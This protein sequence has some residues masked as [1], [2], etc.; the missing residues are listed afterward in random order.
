M[1][2][3]TD[4]QRATLASKSNLNLHHVPKASIGINFGFDPHHPSDNLFYSPPSVLIR[5]VFEPIS[6]IPFNWK[7]RAVIQQTYITNFIPALPDIILNDDFPQ[8]DKAIDQTNPRQFITNGH[9]NPDTRILPTSK[10]PAADFPVSV[11]LP[12]PGP[13]LENPVSQSHL[14]PISDHFV[15]NTTSTPFQHRYPIHQHRQPAHLACPVL[16]SPDTTAS[17]LSVSDSEK[18]EFTIKKGLL[19]EDYKHAVQP[20]ITKEL[21]KMFLTYKALHFINKTDVPANAQFFRFFLFLKLK[22]LPD[23]SFERMSARLCA[24][25]TT[26]LP[27]NA[28]TAYAATGDHHLF[29]LTVNAVLAAAKLEGYL[30]AVQLRRYDIPGAFLQRPLPFPYYGRLPSDLPPPYCN[31]YVRVERCIYGARVSNKI[32]DDDHTATILSIGYSQFEGDPRKFRIVCPTD[33]TKFVIINT[34]VDDGGVIHTWQAKYDET[35]RVLGNRYPGTLDETEMDRYLGMGF[36]Y[37]PI[38]GALTASMYHSIVKA[39]ATFRT[40]SLPIQ[41]TP[42]TMDLFDLTTDPAPVDPVSYQRIVGICIWLLQIRFDIQLPTIMAC[43]HNKAPTQG[44]LIKIIRVLS[45]LK[46][47]AD[48]GPTFLTSDGPTLIASCDAA[49]GV[50]PTTGGSQLSI[51]FRIGKD[52]APFHVISHVQRTKISLNPTHSEYNAFSI[53]TEHIKF[54]RTYLSWLGF[55]Q[56]APT[57]LETDCAP[58]ISILEAPHFP[59]HSK[60][61]LVQDRNVRAA[62]RDGILSPVHVLSKGFATDLNAKPSGP[63]DFLAKRAVLLNIKANPTFAKYL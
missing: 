47:S 14:P 58:A 18:T 36:H 29:L 12:S 24:M 49:F 59:K 11:S 10:L 40:D 2:K 57:P 54:Y 43:T 5:K 38:T 60:N 42:Y 19:M 61:L 16:T 37:N 53:A 28:E 34:H 6:F 56:S 44:D 23:H 20:A 46:G 9:S 52:N 32:F 35:L 21:T 50:H 25:E 30:D 39:L 26:P 45:Y 17:S 27:Q 62:L 63:R 13:G 33:P 48:L 1:I 55:P 41:Q 4:G 7:P 51:S 31:T 3:H 22:F 8:P 15:P